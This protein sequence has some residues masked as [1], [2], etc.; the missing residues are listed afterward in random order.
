MTYGKFPLGAALMLII[1][2]LKG[3]INLIRELDGLIDKRNEYII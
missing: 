2:K 1:N 3:D